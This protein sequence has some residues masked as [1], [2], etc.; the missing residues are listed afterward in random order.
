[1]QS[2]SKVNFIYCSSYSKRIVK[3]KH[4]TRSRAVTK[5]AERVGTRGER[6]R[7]NETENK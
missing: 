2:I 4:M 3:Y 1:M 7:E 6:A 5:G